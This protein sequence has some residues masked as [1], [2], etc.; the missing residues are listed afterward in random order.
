MEGSSSR[1]QPLTRSNV[2]QWR[3]GDLA[4]PRKQDCLS[5][6]LLWLI[7]S[8]GR[9]CRAHDLDFVPRGVNCNLVAADT[10][11]WRGDRGR[12]SV[13]ENQPFVDEVR[14]LVSRSFPA[15]RLLE[16]NH[17]VLGL[18]AL[19]LAIGIKVK[20]RLVGGQVPL[21][22]INLYISHHVDA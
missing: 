8:L 15:R 20:R 5:S 4:C 14:R 19:H 13:D 18:D 16:E 7:G 3:T 22:V 17:F 9:R 11:A 10:A 21:L 6:T 2:L 1:D 12:R